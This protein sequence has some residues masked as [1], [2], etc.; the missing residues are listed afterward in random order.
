VRQIITKD[1][2]ARK[3]LNSAGIFSVEVELFTDDESF[4]A[5]VPEGTS[6]G[7][8]E[9]KRLPPEVAIT[10]INGDV[11][12]K[13]KKTKIESLSDILKFEKQIK[14][15]G[16][17]VTLA[18]SF[19]LLKA[20]AKSKRCEPWQLFTKKKKIPKPL[21][22]I[23]GGGKHAGE[24]SPTFQE[25]LLLGT[26]ADFKKN[27]EQ[28]LQAH[29]QVNKEY[30]PSGKD[31]EGG[32]V[33]DVDNETALKILSH[34]NKNS[35]IGI[36]CAAS[37]FYNTKTKFYEYKNGH[38]LSREA[39]IDFVIKLQKEFCLCYIEDPLHEEDFEGFAIL[40][41]KLG[42]SVL[43]IGDDLF[44]TNP[45]RLKKGISIG[46]CNGCIV[47]PDQIGSLTDVIKFVELAKKHKYT[48][49]ISHRSGETDDDIL[50][51]LAVGLEIP[52]IKIG[53]VG[54]ERISKIN[55]LLKIS[56]E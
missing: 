44:T 18:I 50:A 5:S 42:K 4:V 28:N 7:K 49:V 51:D 17:N 25:F 27:I 34:A 14:K 26:H 21:N 29:E 19:A 31:L 39:Q 6:K 1:V 52:I 23:L 43:I 15:F 11:S 46:A 22:V 56:G 45:E 20:L 13:L 54:G 38:K 30:S 3:I 47:K 55:R 33:M 9:A 53:I 48:P 12:K 10:K 32:W 41:K 24:D 8:H 37:S 40:T 16:S 2:K 35:K 36:D